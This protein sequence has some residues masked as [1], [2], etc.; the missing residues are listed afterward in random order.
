MGG[1]LWLALIDGLA[2]DIWTWVATLVF[3]FWAAMT[4]PDSSE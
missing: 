4:M 1:L 3:V 2:V